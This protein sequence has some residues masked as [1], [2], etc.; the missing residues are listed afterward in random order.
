MLLSC[1][2]QSQFCKRAPTFNFHT[3]SVVQC[4]LSLD[5]LQSNFT[6]FFTVLLQKSLWYLTTTQAIKSTFTD[7]WFWRKAYP[8]T[9]HGL[10]KPH[11]N[12]DRG[13]H[14]LRQWLVAWWHQAITWTNVDLSSKLLWGTDLRTMP[15]NLIRNMCLETRLTAPSL[16][17]Q[18]VNTHINLTENAIPAPQGQCCHNMSVLKI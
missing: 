12:I 2:D 6:S 17:D 18:W 14:W 11:G 4:Q 15:M 10:V 1:G 7:T 5:W 13:Q 8:L 3:I 9:H 16:R